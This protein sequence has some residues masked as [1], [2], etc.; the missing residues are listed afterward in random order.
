[1][2]RKFSSG[3]DLVFFSP[4][5]D[6]V[7]LNKSGCRHLFSAVSNLSSQLAGRREGMNATKKKLATGL[8]HLRFHRAGWAGTI[9]RNGYWESIQLTETTVLVAHTPC[10]VSSLSP[11]LVK[12]AYK[13]MRCADRLDLLSFAAGQIP[14]QTGRSLAYCTNR[15]VSE[16]VINSTLKPTTK[17]N[18]SALISS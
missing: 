17:T 8:G 11:R 14:K 12:K 5:L 4:L 6:G 15:T 13:Y 18:V 10:P 7:T 3:G 1:M 2:K 16:R 9:G